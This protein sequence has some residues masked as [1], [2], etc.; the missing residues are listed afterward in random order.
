MKS[1]VKWL[2]VV[3]CQRE[4]GCW[5]SLHMH[6][7]FQPKHKSLIS[8]HNS[9]GK[10]CFLS[11]CINVIL[12]SMRCTAF[13]R[14]SIYFHKWL[15]TFINETKLSRLQKKND[16]TILKSALTKSI[17]IWFD[18]CAVSISSFRCI[19]VL[20][21]YIRFLMLLTETLCQFWYGFPWD[22]C[23]RVHT[24]SLLYIDHNYFR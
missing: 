24:H 12:I 6:C 13:D 22:S 4:I 5:L 9:V 2:I 16:E 14:P 7:C 20:F 18:E 17:S 1:I 3:E 8:F 11:T 21:P 15:H 23:K 19:L 10:I